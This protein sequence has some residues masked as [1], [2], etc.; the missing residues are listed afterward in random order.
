[1][2]H[3]ILFFTISDKNAAQKQKKATLNTK[4]QAIKSLFLSKF[5][6]FF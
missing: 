3:L 2:Y 4:Q 6:I 1:M 5:S